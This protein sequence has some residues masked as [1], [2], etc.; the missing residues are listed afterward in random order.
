[1]NYAENAGA[2]VVSSTIV[3]GDLDTANLASAT[4]QITGN[5]DLNKDVLELSN[6]LFNTTWDGVNGTLTLTPVATATVL[7]FQTALRQV[8]YRNTSDDPAPGGRTVAFQVDDGTDQSNSLTKT[9]NVTV[10]NDAPTVT[11]AGATIGYTEDG[12][13]GGGA[14]YRRQRSRQRDDDLGDRADLGELRQRTRPAGIQR[15]RAVHG[16][17]ERRERNLDA[18]GRRRDDHGRLSSGAAR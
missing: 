8:T 11:G 18:D 9:I 13:C 15:R 6:V 10:N 16:R 4:V 17:L 5:Y 7:Q 2:T 12:A 14:E 1:M 3:V